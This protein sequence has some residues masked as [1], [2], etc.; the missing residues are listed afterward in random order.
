MS[1]IISLHK[2]IRVIELRKQGL[3]LNEIAKATGI[4][5]GS[6]HNITRKITRNVAK[7]QQPVQRITPQPPTWNM[8]SVP[9]SRIPAPYSQFILPLPFR[10]QESLT[11]PGYNYN[12]PCSNPYRSPSYEKQEQTQIAINDI[13]SN[14][15]DTADLKNEIRRVERAVDKQK[16]E[17]NEHILHWTINKYLNHL[18][19]NKQNNYIDNIKEALS[20]ENTKRNVPETETQEIIQKKNHNKKD[21]RG[22]PI[23]PD[24][25]EILQAMDGIHHARVEKLKIEYKAKTRDIVSDIVKNDAFPI[26]GSILEMWLKKYLK[27]NKKKLPKVVR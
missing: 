24:N 1:K 16:K 7:I 15:R 10:T 17:E 26:M 14:I 3:S 19:K 18:T 5:K 13:I 12:Q 11:H 9:V 25:K 22:E 21:T 2:R 6:V 8:V 27:N 4:S 20:K 23:V